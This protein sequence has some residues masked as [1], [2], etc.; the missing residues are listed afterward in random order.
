[1]DGGGAGGPEQKVA[2]DRDCA[3]FGARDGAF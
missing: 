3:A 1:V 2:A